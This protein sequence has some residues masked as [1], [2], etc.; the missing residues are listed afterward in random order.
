MAFAVTKCVMQVI[1]CDLQV[2]IFKHARRTSEIDEVATKM[3]YIAQLTTSAMPRA[4]LQNPSV[5]AK[6]SEFS[7]SNWPLPAQGTRFLTPQFLQDMLRKNPLSE[8]CYPLAFGYYPEAQGHQMRRRQPP[9]YLLI[10]CV[11]GRGTLE[12]AAEQWPIATGDLIVLPAGAAHAYAADAAEPWSIY[13]VH[14]DGRLAQ[15]Y[16]EL[17][18]L[19]QPIIN[20]GNQPSVAA[21]FESLLALRHSSYTPTPFLHGASLLKTLLTGLADR[22]SRA[23]QGGSGMDINVLVGLMQRQLSRELDLEDLAQVAHLS[24]FHF[25]RRFRQLTGNTPIQYFIHL[26]MQHACRLL[27]SSEDPIKRIAA[28]VGYEDPYYFSRIFKRVIGV[29]PQHYRGSRLA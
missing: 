29:S 17:L 2:T 24:K 12:T 8:D 16:A 27:D 19:S 11:K 22:L 14:F 1:G 18:G 5:M 15:T 4:S 3:D 9:N 23:R 21:E 20:I 7:T 13:W 26:K 28:E 25:I 6:D 10:Y